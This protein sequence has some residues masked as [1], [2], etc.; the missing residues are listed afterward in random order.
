M[1]NRRGILDA[2]CIAAM[3]AVIP[4]FLVG[5]RSV[6]ANRHFAHGHDLLAWLELSDWINRLGQPV[7]LVVGPLILV[8]V[9]VPLLPG[10]R[11][12]DAMRFNLIL[13]TL[14]GDEPH[15]WSIEPG[16]ASSLEA[17]RPRSEREL[18]PW[19]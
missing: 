2:A 14:V 16:V 9:V 4:G 12:S 7:A 8:S 19:F 6:I 17:L 3:L 1:E 10:K 15:P 13:L 11:G 5:A 18:V